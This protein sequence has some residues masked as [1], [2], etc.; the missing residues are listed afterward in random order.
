MANTL[1]RNG[2]KYITSLVFAV[3]TSAGLT[4]CEAPQLSGTNTASRTIVSLPVDRAKATG[5]S[6]V[7]SSP[8]HVNVSVGDLPDEFFATWQEETAIRLVN[9]MKCNSVAQEFTV[10]CTAQIF[11]TGYEVKVGYN[12]RK[13]TLAIASITS[14]PNHHEAGAVVFGAVTEETARNASKL[15]S[16]L[17]QSKPQKSTQLTTTR[18]DDKR[19][20]PFR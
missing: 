19:L 5:C 20:A 14:K 2:S 9:E 17:R 1:F 7:P 10:R 11:G 6:N 18:G 3:V 16:I 4:G 15:A 13:K 12:R 8:R